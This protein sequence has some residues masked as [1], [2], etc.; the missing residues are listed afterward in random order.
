MSRGGP[1]PVDPTVLA[2]LVQAIETG[3][4]A[5][6]QLTEAVLEAV[7][8]LSKRERE[9]IQAMG[10]EDLSVREAA[11]EMQTAR[12]TAHR[13]LHSG[14]DRLATLLATEP[15]VLR[16]LQDGHQT[17]EAAAAE[18]AHAIEVNAM[19]LPPRSPDE[20][21]HNL[22]DL[23]TQM[24]DAWVNRTA[25]IEVDLA[26]LDAGAL[27]Y[28]Q[29]SATMR[30]IVAT[31]I[32]KQRSY[33]A[34][35]ILAFGNTGL[36]V[37]ISDKVERLKNLTASGHTPTHSEPLS[38]TWLDL[39]GYSIVGLMLDNGSFTRPLLEARHAAA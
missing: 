15:S 21:I 39:V 30:N 32:D 10:L 3:V 14:Y 25:D 8:S 19:D 1:V 13:A 38:D 6:S 16:R 31:V 28:Q 18:A 36:A 20:A 33:G 34:G 12:S 27:A 24:A 22:V 37:R 9:A 5:D 29:C 17:W 7:A 35:N 4:V 26:F 11:A 23:R 2:A